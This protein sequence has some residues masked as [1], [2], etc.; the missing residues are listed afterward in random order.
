MTPTALGFN[1]TSSFP[2]FAVRFLQ[3]MFLDLRIDSQKALPAPARH[4]FHEVQTPL[5]Q[6]KPIHRWMASGGDRTSDFAER[7]REQQRIRREQAT[8]TDNKQTQQPSTVIGTNNS[9]EQIRFARWIEQSQLGQ[10]SNRNRIVAISPLPDYITVAD[11]LP[12]IRG[13]VESCSISQF[14][15]IRVIQVQLW[16]IPHFYRSDRGRTDFFARSLSHTLAVT[17]L[18]I[19]RNI[20]QL[21][22]LS[23]GLR[24]PR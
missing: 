24:T 17:I 14:E 19:C 3:R 9:D 18:G 11:M 7:N 10:D 4:D 23:C 1:P 8:E 6:V 16:S 5:S 12:R 2:P 15:Q 22:D 21:L 13:S 20:S